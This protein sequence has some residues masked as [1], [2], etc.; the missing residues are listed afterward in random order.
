MQIRKLDRNTFDVFTG[1]GFDNWTRVR[2]FHWGVKPIAGGRIDRDTLNAIEA[3][4][5]QYPNGNI[6]N[7]VWIQV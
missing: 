2:K 3:A 7:T 6:N 4:V 1:T 5:I